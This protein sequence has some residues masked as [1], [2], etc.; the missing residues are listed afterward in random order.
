MMSPDM[1]QTGAGAVTGVETGRFARRCGVIRLLSWVLSLAAVLVA[2]VY[3]VYVLPFWGV[4]FNASRHG[5]VPLTPPWALECWLWEDDH[6]TESFLKELVDGYAAHDLPVGAVVIDSPWS[7][8]YNDFKVNEA[9]YPDTR[10][11]FADL[12]ARGCRVVLWMTCMVNSYSKD[13]SVR[14]SD[15]FY[16]EARTNGYLAGAGEQLDWWK[17]K[18]G[19]I[20]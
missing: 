1:R 8:R 6:N 5:R 15:D 16:Q 9:R 2:F 14:A 18:G 10:K 3:F 17:G 11:F 4:P 12:H 13:T 7:E 20:D 19:F